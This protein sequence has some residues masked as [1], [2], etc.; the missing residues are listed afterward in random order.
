MLSAILTP[1]DLDLRLLFVLSEF[2]K[3]KR[4]KNKMLGM[5]LYETAFSLFSTLNICHIFE[6]YLFFNVLE[7]LLS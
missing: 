7:K 2:F 1:N 4:P 6:I 5:F 3:N